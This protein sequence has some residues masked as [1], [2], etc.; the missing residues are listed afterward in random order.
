MIVHGGDLDDVAARYGVPRD[1]LIDFSANIDP[2]G[3]PAGV[4]SV[5]AA[6]AANPRMLAPYPSPAYDA[7]RLA[8]AREHAVPVDTVVV[9]HGGAALLDA[10]L[11]TFARS[12]WVVPVPAFSEYARAIAAAHARMIAV[13]LGDAFLPDPGEL[14]SIAAR[15]RHGIM[16]NTPHNPSASAMPASDLDELIDGARAR[17]IALIVDEA[18]ADY[19]PERS[20]IARAVGTPAT[21]VVRSL[22]KFYALAGVRVG[23]AIA[24]PALAT[25]M[26]EHLPS[27]PVGSLDAAIAVAALADRAYANVTRTR[28]ARARERL[29]AALA[30]IGLRPYPSV[31]NYLFIELPIA[32]D[33]LDCVLAKLVDCGV[34][35]RDCRSYR[36]LE[37]RAAIRVAVLDDPSNERLV[38]ALQAA[39][40]VP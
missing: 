39:L 40:A 26:R 28:T 34:V 30:R 21:I 23:Y 20:C 31:A 24:H 6:A 35:V 19:V 11:Q 16:V 33:A 38:T 10:A 2:Y 36:G 4:A 29:C 14:L 5:L 7:L 3:P 13:P 15:E 9:G 32:A 17:G 25:R 8:I 18:F 37:E 12:G 1:G 27:W 22:T